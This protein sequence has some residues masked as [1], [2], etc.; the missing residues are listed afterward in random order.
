MGDRIFDH[1]DAEGASPVGAAPASSSSAW[2]QWTEQRH[3]QDETR[4]V[5]VLEFGAAYIRGLTV[6]KSL[7]VQ[8]YVRE[9]RRYEL[10]TIVWPPTNAVR[11]DI[12]FSVIKMLL[13]PYAFFGIVYCKAAELQNQY[14]IVANSH[15]ENRELSWCQLVA[16]AS[17]DDKVGIVTSLGF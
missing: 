8:W 15:P 1:S 9:C 13:L 12:E 16:G 2:L 14:Q 17:S 6:L 7:V 11:N 5:W 10:M 4:N 3:L